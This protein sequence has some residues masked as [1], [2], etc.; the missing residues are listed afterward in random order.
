MT[1]PQYTHI[2]MSHRHVGFTAMSP[3]WVVSQTQP[4]GVALPINWGCFSGSMLS[5]VAAFIDL[6][7]N[8]GNDYSSWV[9]GPKLIKP[10]IQQFSIHGFSL[11]CQWIQ[12]SFVA[13]LQP[14]PRSE[15]RS[16][17]AN[18]GVPFGRLRMPR[19]SAWRVDHN[20]TRLAVVPARPLSSTN[21]I[22]RPSY[23]I[24]YLGNDLGVDSVDRSSKHGY[25]KLYTLCV[26]F[27]VMYHFLEIVHV[28]VFGLIR[29]GSWTIQCWPWICGKAL[30]PFTFGPESL[31]IF[32][33]GLG[34][35]NGCH[36]C[37]VCGI[38][39]FVV[40]RV[41]RLGSWV[42]WVNLNVD[43]SNISSL[44]HTPHFIH[45]SCVPGASLPFVF[46]CLKCGIQKPDKPSR[47]MPCLARQPSKDSNPSGE[48]TSTTT[49]T[50]T[51]TVPWQYEQKA[52]AFSVEHSVE[53]KHVPIIS[54]M[55]RKASRIN[56][57]ATSTT[58]TLDFVW[59]HDDISATLYIN[60]MQW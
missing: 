43:I 20:W 35:F 54:Y 50:T 17:V 44:F 48:I 23:A 7:F 32:N 2:R 16:P 34:N 14:H 4:M 13:Q 38:I 36:E 27:E 29:Y 51:A 60:L 56:A 40:F 18:P 45:L 5:L 19:T 8:P 12:A 42:N 39:H 46:P 53:V 21:H 15:H 28:V 25:E 49:T 37:L 22:F 41:I 33:V 59:A 1:I 11:F 30:E 6:L 3:W 58:S 9:I 55:W 26:W 57:E 24:V 10:I 31:E 52:T 47:F